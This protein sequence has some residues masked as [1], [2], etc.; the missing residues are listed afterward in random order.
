[1]AS[2]LELRNSGLLTAR[3]S[4]K[5]ELGTRNVNM[6]HHELSD[7]NVK[8]AVRSEYAKTMMLRK[9]IEIGTEELGPQYTRSIKE[10]VDPP[11]KYAPNLII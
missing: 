4:K 11:P 8:K 3:P 9:P 5:Q 6:L 1:M 10:P 2:K 7:S